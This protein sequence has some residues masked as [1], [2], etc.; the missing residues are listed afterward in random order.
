MPA[1][2]AAPSQ[3]RWT[4]QDLRE[5]TCQIGDVD[6]TGH[7]AL[8]WQHDFQPHDSRY[9]F[10]DPATADAAGSFNGVR[11]E[12]IGEAT[13]FMGGECEGAGCFQDYVVVGPTGHE[14]FRSAHDGTSTYDFQANDPTGGMIHERLKSDGSSVQVLLEAI[15]TAGDVRWTRQLGPAFSVDKLPPGVRLG[16]DRKGNVLAIWSSSS[17]RG[18]QWFDH[19]GNPGAEF[20]PPSAII[21]RIFERVGDGL[22]VYGFPAPGTP[23]R[24]LGQYEPLATR[25]S[26]PP[27]WLAARAENSLHMV[28][29]GRGYAMLPNEGSSPTCEQT[30][31]VISPSGELCG[32]LDF[33]VGGGSCTTTPMLVGY[34]GTVVQQLPRERENEC[35]AAGH[36]CDCTYRYWP[37]YFH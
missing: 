31:A 13:G 32:T 11:L 18:A 24:W 25:M 5:G 12:L 28:H 21:A 4:N 15:G 27:A 14:D 3:F 9:V 23:G 22:F 19:D 37:G 29:G 10:V 33:G 34:D 36:V 26:D 7:L 20:E 8:F 16:V 2:P 1:A 30:I 17:G 35:T 6:G